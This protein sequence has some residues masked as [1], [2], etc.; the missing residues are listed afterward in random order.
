MR[1]P[2]TMSSFASGLKRLATFGLNDNIQC[3]LACLTTCLMNSEGPLLFHD[4]TTIIIFITKTEF[5]IRNSKAHK[6]KRWPS[7]IHSIQN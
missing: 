4:D 5:M 6:R 2:D 1:D 3:V 7:F